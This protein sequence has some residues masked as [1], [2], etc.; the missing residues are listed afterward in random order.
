MDIWMWIGL[1][2]CV[3]VA[4]LVVQAVI[5]S[6]KK[7]ELTN[8]LN[9]HPNFTAT[10]EILGEDGKS[11]IAI[12]ET[13]KKIALIQTQSMGCLV[14]SFS[15]KDVLSSEIFVDG[16]TYTQTVRTSQLG[17]ALI[18]GLALGGVGAI[19]G[20]LSG[21]SKS[22]EKVKSIKLRVFVN[23]INSPLHEVNFLVIESKKGTTLYNHA[24]ENAQ[25]AHASI[26]AL[27]KQADRE[28]KEKEAEQ[29]QVKNDNIPTSLADELSKLSELRDK[30]ILT[31]KEFDKQKEKLLS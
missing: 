15:Y 24:M 29:P 27:I 7:S 28:D 21:K 31:D 26:G 6:K 2:F 19:I 23:E 13:R 11:G 12:D 16:E 14:K 5:L 9:S 30:G 18:G 10:L 4:V 1:F 17:G 8:E 25:R 20:G 22:S 3:V